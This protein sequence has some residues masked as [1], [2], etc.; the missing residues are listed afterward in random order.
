MGYSEASRWAGPQGVVARDHREGEAR[1]ERRAGL[2][3][4]PRSGL[5]GVGGGREAG[6]DAGGLSPLD[7][8]ATRADQAEARADG[9]RLGLAIRAGDQ[10]GAAGAGRARGF[11]GLERLGDHEDGPFR[12]RR[13][14]GRDTPTV[15]AM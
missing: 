15:R 8:E 12:A 9:L 11:Q 5:L 4:E 3:G 1:R 2:V 13:T 7:G 10:V 14:V 6:A